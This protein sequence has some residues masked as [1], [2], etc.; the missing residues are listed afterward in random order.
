M[1][2][3]RHNFPLGKKN[4]YLTIWKLLFLES[5]SY[6]SACSL[7]SLSVLYLAVNW[8]G[9]YTKYLTERAQRK[10]FLETRRSLETRYRTQQENERQEKLLLSVLPSFVAQQLIRQLVLF[11]QNQREANNTLGFKNMDYNLFSWASGV[12]H[13][14][15]FR[16]K[17]ISEVMQIIPCWRFPWDKVPLPVLR[18]VESS[19]EQRHT[20]F[21]IRENC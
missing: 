9:S 8:S 1:S 4:E 19:W 5:D 10:A 11:W 18:A 13:H 15:K 2:L 20:I 7:G 6:Y 14:Y 12:W 21:L 16:N 17:T 3:K